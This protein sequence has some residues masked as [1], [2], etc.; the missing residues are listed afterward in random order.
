MPSVTHPR[1]GDSLAASGYPGIVLD[2]LARQAADLLDVGESCIFARD[3]SHPD[4][5]IVAAAHG[6]DEAIVGQRVPVA[7]ENSRAQ[8]GTL[9]QLRW[10]GDVQGALSVGTAATARP[11]PLPSSSTALL[12]ELAPT[13]AAA[14][15]HAHMRPDAP[16]DMRR[17]I[18]GLAELEVAALLHD[19]GKLLVPDSILKKPG[20]LT[21]D[22]HAVMAQ[23]PTGG[24]QIL[25]ACLDSRWWPR[26]SAT[27][28]SAGMDRDTRTAS[29]ARAYHSPAASSR[30][31]TPTTR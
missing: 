23:H 10:D 31:A 27:T 28:T 14:I 25:A 19:I 18:A 21:P 26:S 30:S 24:A 17:T 9:V 15:W 2:R 29:P 4:Q 7:F 11:P 6:A 16:P 13:A 22:E 8:E 12:E 20:P 1:P 3:R 5:A